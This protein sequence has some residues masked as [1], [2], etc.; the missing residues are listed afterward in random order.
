MVL[1]SAVP[2]QAKAHSAETWEVILVFRGSSCPVP[3]SQNPSLHCM[4]PKCKADPAFK[5]Q[6]FLSLS[7]RSSKK[8]FSPW[9]LSPLYQGAAIRTL[10]KN[11]WLICG[12]LC[13]FFNKYQR[14]VWFGRDHGTPSTKWGYSETHSIWSWTV[15][16]MRS[17]QPL[18]TQKMILEE[19][20][21][22]ESLLK[23]IK[24]CS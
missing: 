2:E 24:E 21:A 10:K 6:F 23:K 11:S 22:I 8:N 4:I 19:L 1:I 15:P 13:C 12:P 9:F 3:S 7:I 20:Q 5:L 18:W 17:P 16:G 14:M